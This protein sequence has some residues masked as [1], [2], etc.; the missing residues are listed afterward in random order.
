MQQYSV[1]EAKARFSEVLA[2]VEA[3]REVIITR[4]GAPVA[5]ISAVESPRRPI[6]FAAIDALRSRLPLH[7]ET[8]AELIRRMRDEKY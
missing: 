6:D 3:G 5:R 4:R 1:A 2:Q 8:G 7:E